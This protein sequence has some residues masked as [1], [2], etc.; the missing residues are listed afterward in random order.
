MQKPESVD[1]YI[2]AAPSKARAK[3]VQLRKTIKAAAPKALERIS[4]RMPYYGYKGRLAYCAGPEG[5]LFGIFEDDK[6]AK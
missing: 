1:A 2:K 5:N 4:Y 6:N 3:L